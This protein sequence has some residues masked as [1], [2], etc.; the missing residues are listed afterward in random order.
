VNGSFLMPPDADYFEYLSSMEKIVCWDAF[1]ARH[2]ADVQMFLIQYKNYKVLF[3]IGL[4]ILL[5][6][7]AKYHF[8]PNHAKWFRLL[9]LCF[10]YCISEV[11]CH[12]L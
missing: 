2:W 7:W 12:F 8:W 6:N 3:K 5:Q 11:N 1:V 9:V 10:S 4:N